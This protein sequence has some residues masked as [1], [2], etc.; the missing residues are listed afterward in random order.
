MS[1]QVPLPLDHLHSR[2]SLLFSSH[3]R[4]LFVRSMTLCMHTACSIMV[5]TC[6]LP[7]SRR[8][9]CTSVN[10]HHLPNSILICFI[11]SNK[12]LFSRSKLIKQEK[13]EHW[14]GLEP[15][16]LVSGWVPLPLDHL[17]SH[18]HCSFSSQPKRFFLSVLWPWHCA[19]TLQCSYYGMHM[20]ITSYR[21]DVHVHRW[22]ITICQIRVLICF[23][24]SN[25][26]TFL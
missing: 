3:L 23:I 24:C 16:S 6:T 9:T 17:H 22:T 25:K 10:Y 7:L 12:W 11:C 5:C 26:M 18:S 14:L 19:C 8:C 13:F 4:A 21:G 20:H 1:G 15:R 2:F